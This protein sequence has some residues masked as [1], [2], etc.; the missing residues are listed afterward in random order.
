MCRARLMNALEKTETQNGKDAAFL[1]VPM[2]NSLVKRNLVLLVL[3]TGLAACG[4]D[5][6]VPPPAP[7]PVVVTPAPAPT[8]SINP[9]WDY[10]QQSMIPYLQAVYGDIRFIDSV[11]FY[12]LNGSAVIAAGTVMPWAQL[13]TQY[14]IPMVQGCGCYVATPSFFNQYGSGW[15]A[16]GDVGFTG[17]ANINYDNFNLWIGGSYGNNSTN[18][19]DVWNRARVSFARYPGSVVAFDDVFLLLYQAQYNY[20]YSYYYIY[21]QSYFP[22]WNVPVYN[23]GN[24]GSGSFNF[25]GDGWSIDVRGFFGF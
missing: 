21:Y 9:S 11:S 5:A 20:Y 8:T 17:W 14:I 24:F 25:G 23:Q 22:G 6:V 18:Y 16:S 19:L 1:E 2:F 7:P 12:S 13:Y 4:D 10:V 3:A 15:G